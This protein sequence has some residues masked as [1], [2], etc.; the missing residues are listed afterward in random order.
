MIFCSILCR[1]IQKLRF[2][3][4][5]LSTVTRLRRAASF[6]HSGSLNL[7]QA[8]LCR[9]KY[10][11]IRFL[12]ESQRIIQWWFSGQLTIIER[13]RAKKIPVLIKF[14]EEFN[15]SVAGAGCP[16]PNAPV[17]GSGRKMHYRKEIVSIICLSEECLS[18]TMKFAADWVVASAD[19]SLKGRWCWWMYVTY[20]DLIQF[21]IMECAVITLVF[22][23]L[24][25]KWVQKWP[26][27]PWQ[28]RW[29]FLS[30]ESPSQMGASI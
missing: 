17:S 5:S 21:V 15:V 26:P 30:L 24:K 4:R 14:W 3:I 23:F 10:L 27:R 29:P 7:G 19:L 18:V 20:S 12:S 13:E 22:L 8:W 2:Y 28:D 25:E 9:M 16:L 11:P 6:A 1:M